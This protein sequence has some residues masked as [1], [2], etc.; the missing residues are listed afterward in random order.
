MTQ[1]FF[2]NELKYIKQ[3]LDSENKSN[4]TGS[5]NHQLEHTFTK[6][7]H[8]KYAITHNSGTSAL[9]IGLLAM[10]VGKGDEVISPA[11]TVMMDTFA[12]LYTGSIP[13]Y[14]DIDPNTFNIDPED[15]IKKITPHTKAI[16]AVHLY[17][18][19]CDINYIM[20]IASEHNIPVIED[21][22]QCYLSSCN[23]RLAG[24]IAD[25]SIFSFENS[26]HISVG[27]GG[28]TLTNNKSLAEKVRKYAG[29]GF[30]NLTASSGQIKLNED[31]FQN[32]NYKRHDTLG[33]NYRLPELNAAVAVAQMENI[34]QIVNKR[35]HIAKLFEDAISG[36]SW[37]IPQ[38]VP[39]NYT[40]SYWTYAVKYEGTSW[41][42]FR[43]TFKQL[44]GDGF[45]AA[46][47]IPYHEPVMKNHQWFYRCPI[48][49]SLQPKIMQFKTNYRDIKLAEKQALILKETI[50]HY[51]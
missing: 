32:P 17:G 12:T 45:Y 51:D 48:A 2:G 20:E 1:K 9:H 39:T 29:I 34:D 27:E 18:L 37:L 16:I 49:E 28:I 11:L 40:S 46:W 35:I 7:F 44:G 5:W 50:Q 8:T 23:K 22:A 42:N 13:V 41:S 14:A 6:K 25:L 47:S 10:G 3:V 31:I 38:K 24:S 21:S 15:I 30:K 43:K 33:Y 26:K 4:T 19:P 36:C